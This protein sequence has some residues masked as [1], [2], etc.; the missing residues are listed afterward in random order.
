MAI[1]PEVGK[2]QEVGINNLSNLKFRKRM[3]VK[4]LRNINAVNGEEW[5]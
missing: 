5:S 1:L 2:S 4:H 3:N